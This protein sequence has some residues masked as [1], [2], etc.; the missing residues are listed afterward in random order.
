MVGLPDDYSA[1]LCSLCTEVKKLV[2]KQC[3]GIGTTV[4]TVLDAID[5]FPGL[6]IVSSVGMDHPLSIFD[7][8]CYFTIRFSR[9]ES[10]F[11]QT[12]VLPIF[13]IMEYD[14]VVGWTN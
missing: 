4:K 14:V 11:I 10:F 3:K 9:F 6:S 5:A 2:K 8:K 7:I 13:P 12:F 1:F